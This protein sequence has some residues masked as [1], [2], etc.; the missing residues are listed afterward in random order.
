M[1]KVTRQISYYKKIWLQIMNSKWY[2]RDINVLFEDS[3]CE[4]ARYVSQ[5]KI[6]VN[7]QVSDQEYK[8]LS[9]WI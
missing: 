1:D 4:F 6:Q 5:K 8:L 2:N 9:P 3:I 7:T